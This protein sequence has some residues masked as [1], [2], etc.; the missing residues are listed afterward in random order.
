VRGIKD[1]LIWI[2]PL[3]GIFSLSPEDQEAARTAKL[4]SAP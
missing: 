1:H 4:A 3:V 2:E